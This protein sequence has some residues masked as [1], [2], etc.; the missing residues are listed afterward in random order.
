MS[1]YNDGQYIQESIYSVLCQTYVDFE[2]IIID[3]GST[4][5][6]KD[7]IA[8]IY[9]ERI[10][11]VRNKKNIGL[12]ENLN[13]GISLAYGEYIARLDSDDLWKDNEKLQKQVD[14][15]DRHTEYGIIGTCAHVYNKFGEKLFSI[16]CPSS[17]EEIRSR[18]FVVNPFVHSSVVFRKV[19]ALECGGYSRE[20]KYVEDYGLW[21][22]IAKKA[23]CFNLK[24]YSVYYRYNEQGITQQHN[25]KQVRANIRLLHKYK[26]AYGRY[27]YAMLKWRIKELLLFFGLQTTIN[28]C[29]RIL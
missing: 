19:V 1:T 6:T 20:E 22:R 25:I 13:T 8:N 17:D 12:I 21:M 27:V 11:Y 23:K 14:F 10:R 16:E 29:K 18:M 15:L 5:N 2:L 24:S 9:D 7:I 3:D 26:G 4:D 28:R